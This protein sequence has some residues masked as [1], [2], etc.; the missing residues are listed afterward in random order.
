[1]RRITKAALGG[2][3]GCALVVGGTGVASGELLD[4]LKVH[5]NSNDVN[6][7]YA[8]LDA[9]K[10]KITIDNGTDNTT[11]FSV[12][13][14][15]IDVSEVD[16]SQ[17][18]KPLGSHLH[19]GKCEEGDFGNST[20]SPGGKAGPHYNHDVHYYRKAFPQLVNGVLE[21]PS[22]TVAAI[23][24]DTEVW[25]EFVPDEEGMAYD[26]TTV[27]FVPVDSDGDMAVVVHVDPTNPVTGGAGQRQVCF[28][29]S[30]RG[31][32]EEPP[33]G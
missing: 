15:G 30:V 24:D 17:P 7:S 8:T 16:F 21:P 32:F 1:V 22:D 12:R 18:V 28:P 33:T 14:T 20:A 26:K 27:P 29:L 19:I 6:T 31:I 5:R 11:T 23:T 25:F 13:I 4:F 2:L 10:A 9:A 3:A